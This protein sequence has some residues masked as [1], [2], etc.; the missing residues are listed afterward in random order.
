MKTPLAILLA[1]LAWPA[2]AETERLRH[3]EDNSFLLEEA[4]NQEDGVVHNATTFS[5]D[6]DTKDWIATFTQEWPLVTEDHQVSYTL[7]GSGVR[8]PGDRRYEGLGDLALHYRYQAL[9]DDARTALAPRITL[10]V[11]TG[12]SSRGLGTGGVG[13]QANLPFSVRLGTFLA[14]HSNLGGGWTPSGKAPDGAAA[15]YR[16]L[17]AGQSLI[18]LLGYRVNALVELLWT[19]TQ[20]TTH[21]HTTRSDAV[22][23]SPGVR[24]GFDVP[25]GLQIVPGLAVPIG[26][27]PSAGSL[28]VFGYLSF[29]FPFAAPAVRPGQG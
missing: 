22:F 18:A 7:T 3:L 13:V 5:R 17:F 29:E 25:G 4:Y 19:G 24:L 11:P 16:S 23:V 14:A 12:A 9:S 2:T 20:T 27:G 28:S 26:I 15:S 21:G 8:G 6:R 1:A 10:L